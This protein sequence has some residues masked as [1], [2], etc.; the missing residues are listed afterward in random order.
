MNSMAELELQFGGYNQQVTNIV[1]TNGFIDP[2]LYDGIVST[3]A[4]NASV[5][6]IDCKTGFFFHSYNL[7][8]K[9][10]FLF[11]KQTIRVQ[12]T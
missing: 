11:T 2:W 3:R 1:Y 5:I 8:Y 7:Q 6:N 4:V 12:Q 10:S 9:L